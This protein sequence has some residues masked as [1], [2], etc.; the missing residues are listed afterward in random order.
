MIDHVT[1]DGWV[2]G[3]AV[4]GKVEI[5]LATISPSFSFELHLRTFDG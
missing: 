3:W 1:M 5:S 2:D 4:K